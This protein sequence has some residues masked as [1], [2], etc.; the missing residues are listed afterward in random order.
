MEVILPQEEVAGAIQALEE[1]DTTVQ[2]ADSLPEAAVY[3]PEAVVYHLEEAVSSPAADLEGEETLSALPACATHVSARMD[4]RALRFAFTA[5]RLHV[6][7]IKVAEEAQAGQEGPGG[8]G[9]P[10]G[11]EEPRGAQ[12]GQGGQ[13]G[14]GGPRGARGAQGGQEGPGGPGGPRGD[15]GGPRSPRV[16]QTG[17]HRIPGTA[18]AHCFTESTEL[19][20]IAGDGP[21]P[22]PAPPPAP[23]E[24][25]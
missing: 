2:V 19:K 10:G 1:E 22:P 7:A 4:R 3:L 9:E 17:I 12:G 5:G 14:P 23:P 8:P 21:N 16:S 20:S 18:Q 11:P 15:P 25:V 24:E 13:G 6:F